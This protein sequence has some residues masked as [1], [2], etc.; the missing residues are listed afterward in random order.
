MTNRAPG[1]LS[2]KE[3]EKEGEA[4]SALSDSPGSASAPLST[5]SL[6][7][8]CLAPLSGD[9][10]IELLVCYICVAKHQS[11]LIALKGQYSHG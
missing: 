8:T 1:S 9:L 5:V 11:D 4:V 10:G 2:S 6:L 3:N 7:I